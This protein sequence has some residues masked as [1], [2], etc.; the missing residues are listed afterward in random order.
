MISVCIPTY[1]GEQFIGAQISSILPQ[2]KEED[3][4][5]ISDDGSTD[6]TLKIL[7]SFQD[8]RIRIFKHEKIRQKFKFCYTAKNLENAL[9][10]CQGDIIFL[11][12]QDDIWSNDK[13][14]KFSE[15]FKDCSIILSDCSIVDKDLNVI[16]PSKFNLEKIKLSPIHNIIKCGYLG[17][18]LA[19]KR[20]LLEYI[21]P[22]PN[23]LPHDFWIGIIGYKYG[24]FKM[25][26]YPTL[27]YRRHEFAVTSTNAQLTNK[28]N[29]IPSNTNSIFFKVYYRLYLIKNYIKL[30]LRY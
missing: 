3:E 7:E 23:N 14:E 15:M 27:L 26:E 2:L 5:V 19:F 1:N 25:L 11:S 12:D 8:S 24:K 17:C 22:I 16:E 18:C 13:I 6:E 4:I 29:T 28:F 20:E 9:T 21:L 30:W 10:H